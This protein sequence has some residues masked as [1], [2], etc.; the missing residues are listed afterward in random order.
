MD[1][2]D[3]GVRALRAATEAVREAATPQEKQAA[4]QAR[5]ALVKEIRSQEGDEAEAFG[6]FSASVFQ[7]QIERDIANRERDNS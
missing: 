2:N 3:P 1:E 5:L 4:D 7:S 6:S